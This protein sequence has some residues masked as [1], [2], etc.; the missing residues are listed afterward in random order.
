MIVVDTSAIIAILSDEA[1]AA[2]LRVRL[3]EEGAAVM[4]AAN[5]LELQMVLAGKGAGRGWS[6]VEGLLSEYQI[7]ISPFDEVQLAAARD[8]AIRFGKGR[9]K[10]KLNFGDCFAY[11]LAKSESLPLLCTGRDF[12]HTDIVLA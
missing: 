4:S 10:A 3:A 8:A 2:R 5:A 9:H 11:A 1:D 7:A 12:V 6:E